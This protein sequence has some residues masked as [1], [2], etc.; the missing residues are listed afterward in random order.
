VPHRQLFET[1]PQE[2]RPLARGIDGCT[3]QNEKKLLSAITASDILPAR[4]L[5]QEIAKPTQK[6]VPCLMAKGIVEQFDD[7][8]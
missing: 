1:F 3:G 6:H 7:N 2:F 5:T 8:A 4:P